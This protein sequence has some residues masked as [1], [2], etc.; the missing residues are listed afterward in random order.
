MPQLPNLSVRSN[1]R[2]SV[3]ELNVV[4]HAC[5]ILHNMI[6]ELRNEWDVE[7][8]DE[9]IRS[10]VIEDGGPLMPLLVHD[11]VDDDDNPEGMLLSRAHRLIDLQDSVAHAHL[12]SDLVE[13]LWNFNK[14]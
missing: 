4:L 10:L 9:F 5:V 1:D 13:H 7:R 2:M 12:F 8:V 11:V 3:K 6:V 14:S